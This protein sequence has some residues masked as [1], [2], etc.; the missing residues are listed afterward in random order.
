M[1]TLW[2][3]QE[4]HHWSV[5]IHDAAPGECTHLADLLKARLPF[6]RRDT[7]Q[8]VAD[9][10]EAL[11]QAQSTCHRVLATFLPS[12]ASP[13]ARKKRIHRCFQDEQLT[14]DVFL[15]VLLPL[16]PPGKLILA[17]D[18]T[19]WTHGTQP[20]NLLVLGVVL[21]GFTLPLVWTALAHQGSSDTATRERLVA[22]LLRHLPAN[23]WKVLI[24]DREFIGQNWFRFLRRRRIKRC[25]RVK[26]SARVDG[27]RLDEV[28]ADLAPG[29]IV[30][31]MDK[32]VIYGC[33][34]Q[35]VVT[36][37]VAGDLVCLA[38]D[39]HA[40]DACWMYRLRWSV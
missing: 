18:R 32:E 20:L 21:H 10:I 19:N 5:T 30:A 4:R 17:L 15:H 8:R 33:R 3:A 16:L 1:T 22:R 13:E 26:G 23:R 28:Y 25:V 38:T 14:D 31:M 35:I 37:S 12:E 9:V 11:I 36:R 7:L 40:Q 29:R 39:L 24:A 6:L 34:M 2:A 27:D